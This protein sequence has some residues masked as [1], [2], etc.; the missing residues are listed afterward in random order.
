MVFAKQKLE[1]SEDSF[2]EDESYDINTP[3]NEP[4]G[5]PRVREMISEEEKHT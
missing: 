2:T 3:K 5:M 4:H 1:L